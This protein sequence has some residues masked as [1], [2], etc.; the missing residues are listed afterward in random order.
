MN[1]M[2]ASPRSRTL[3]E[4]EYALTQRNFDQIAAFL[5]EETGIALTQTKATLVYSRLAK[6]IRKLGLA[7]FDEYCAFAV[8]PSGAGERT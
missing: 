1:P 4:G 7:S 2:A 6:R 3:I 5:K 8:S